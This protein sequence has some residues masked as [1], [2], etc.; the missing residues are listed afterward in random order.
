[1]LHQAPHDVHMG[2]AQDDFELGLPL[3]L[4]DESLNDAVAAG[5]Q[6]LKMGYSSKTNTSGRSSAYLKRYSNTSSIR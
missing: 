3:I 5:D 4:I 6:L 1:M 2:P